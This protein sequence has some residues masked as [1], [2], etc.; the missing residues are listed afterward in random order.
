M[1]ARRIF[2]RDSVIF[3]WFGCYPRETPSHASLHP[4]RPQTS[5]FARPPE[6]STVAFPSAGHRLRAR[7]NDPH[8]D[9]RQPRRVGLGRE[10]VFRPRARRKPGHRG[11]QQHLPCSGHR[12]RRI[13]R[14]PLYGARGE[15]LQRLALRGRRARL[16]GRSRR[17]IPHAFRRHRRRSRDQRVVR[18]F[19]AVRFAQR[20]S[21]FLQDRQRHPPAD[22]ADHQQPGHPRRRPAPSLGLRHS[23]DD[24][25][26]NSAH[27]VHLRQH[28]SHH[29]T[30]PLGRGG[31]PKRHLPRARLRQQHFFQRH[32]HSRDRSGRALSKVQGRQ[33]FRHRH[34]HRQDRQLRG[35]GHPQR[36]ARDRILQLRRFS[37]RLRQPVRTTSPR[38]RHHRQRTA[39]RRH[40]LCLLP[41]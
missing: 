33:P 29:R 15:R 25:L 18:H 1:P 36:S 23:G 20:G 40:R 8:V 41:D 34:D 21:P 10:L 11:L 26:Q 38:I 7:A 22:R 5:L 4:S 19:G 12:G 2:L 13:K 39:Y 9:R 37:A 14:F 27:V 6:I 31:R 30:L 28:Q 3:R 16:I 17:A 24:E 35:G 32:H